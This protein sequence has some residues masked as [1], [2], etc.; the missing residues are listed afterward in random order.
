MVSALAVLAV[1]AV[2]TRGRPATPPQPRKLELVLPKETTGFALSPDA[3]RL[4]FFQSGQLR[5]LDLRR[6]EF[7]DLAPAPI[8]AR[9]FV[10]WSPDSAFVGYNT[11]DGKLWKVPAH[12]GAPLVVC[13][14]P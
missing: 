4:A 9:S 11:V 5:M 7:H 12:G 8:G 2:W 13:D 3:H 6:L 14:I 1:A 10:F